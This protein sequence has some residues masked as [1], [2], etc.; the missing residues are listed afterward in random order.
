MCFRAFA[1]VSLVFSGMAVARSVCGPGAGWR[2]F[3]LQ[4]LYPLRL[5]WGV[6][7]LL[8]RGS[9]RL[10]GLRLARCWFHVRPGSQWSAGSGIIL[11]PLAGHSLIAIPG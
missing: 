7:L 11:G 3:R 10:L 4:A 5:G 8:G 1:G 2:A 9:G 6:L